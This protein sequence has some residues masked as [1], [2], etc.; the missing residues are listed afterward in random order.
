[1]SATERPTSHPF[2]MHQHVFDQPA[3]IAAAVA[4][5]VSR[6]ASFAEALADKDRLWFVGIG[7]SYHAALL[8]EFFMRV[9]GGGLTAIASHSFDFAL[10]GPELSDRDAVIVISHTGRRNYSVQALD[11]V[12][13]SP[14]TLA[15]VTGEEGA[16][17]H[18]GLEHV[19]TTGGPD[20]SATYTI[21]FTSA[22]A[23]LATIAAA[24]GQQRTGTPTLAPDVLARE[25]PD[26]MRGALETEGVI[27]ELARSHA[28]HRKVWLS[29]AGPAGVT[30]ME[31]A[32][33]I[34][35]ASWLDAEGMS[36]EQLLHG[37]FAAVESEDLVVVV[38]PAGAGQA[39][40]IT[41]SDE[42]REIGADRIVVSDGTPESLRDG[43]AGWVV[44][45]E[46]VEPLSA[47]TTL[48]PLQL[49]AYWFA[50]ERGTN[51][52]RARLD[53]ERYARAFAMMK[54]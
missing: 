26:A 32:L 42:V 13:S 14:A 2:N 18:S 7:T 47:L 29:G 33:K 37:P 23:V 6:A 48:V 46:I 44:V 30:A 43:A 40:T 53:D 51:P 21:S 22:L 54:F 1:M 8:G 11:R 52:D 15:L 3:A 31:A 4:A 36:T 38:A 34:K 5:T 35:E 19:F 12:G 49:L 9:F 28:G 50:I 41:L 10:Y 20:R 17:R 24:I 45:P 39:R 16:G 25:L 27:R